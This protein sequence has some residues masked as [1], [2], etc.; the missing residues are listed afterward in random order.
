MGGGGGTTTEGGGGEGGCAAVSVHTFTLGKSIGLSCVPGGSPAD[1]FDVSVPATGRALVSLE[2][3]L[4]GVGPASA[5]VHGWSASVQAG[6]PSF[7]RIIN[8]GA[9]ED[10]CPGETLTRKLLAYGKLTATHD[11]VQVPM[12]QYRDTACIDG[13]VTIADTSTLTVWV[14]DPAEAC[15]ESGI[16]A[17][18]YFREVWDVHGSGADM[19]ISMTTT[20]NDVLS[21][22]FVVPAN[23][24]LRVLSQLEMSPSSTLNVCGD[25]FQTGVAAITHEGSYLAVE[26]L[27]YPQSGGQTHLLLAPELFMPGAPP[28]PVEYGIAA[29]VNQTQQVGAPVGATFSGDTVLGIVARPSQ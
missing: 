15:A 1:V 10:L 28:G 21:A 18:S 6:D 11:R 29:A 2:L 19:P 27:G 24:D 3:D 16:V 13:V 9:G 7:D 26:E 25:R 14:E 8:F 20:F 4:V 22:P 5:G 12:Y 23:A 17:R